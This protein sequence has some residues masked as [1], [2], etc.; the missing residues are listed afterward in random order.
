MDPARIQ[1]VAKALALNT[2]TAKIVAAFRAASIPSILLKGPAITTRFY[3]EG[4]RLYGDIDLLVPRTVAASAEALLRQEGFTYQLEQ[5]RSWEQNDHSRH[6]VHESRLP[7]DLHFRF[8]GVG[9]AHEEIWSAFSRSAQSMNI[10]RVPVTVLDPSDQALILALHAMH[11]VHDHK[12]WA[13]KDLCRGIDALPVAIW[14][15]ALAQSRR[16]QAE[17]FFSAGLRLSASGNEL[18]ETIGAMTASSESAEAWRRNT[19]GGFAYLR[20]WSQTRGVTA[21]LH[22]AASMLI[23][24]RAHITYRWPFARRG[25]VAL[26]TAYAW[27][28]CRT[29]IRFPRAVWVFVSLRRS[30]GA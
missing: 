4:E 2:A 24:S 17:P 12:S 18:A 5:G 7:V 1:R 8:W 10:G 23:P 26:A 11:H 22:L 21:K 13:L 25:Y 6:W 30:V 14:E 15:E 9:A 3:D 27:H 19:V 28:L 16:L 29:I 20:R